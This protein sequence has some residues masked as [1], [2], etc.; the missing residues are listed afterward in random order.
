MDTKPT[1]VGRTKIM[2][3]QFFQGSQAVFAEEIYFILFLLRTRLV[4]SADKTEP[5]SY[6]V[7]PLACP[8]T[9]PPPPNPK[10][11]MPSFIGLGTLNLVSNKL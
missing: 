3:P 8:V 5:K 6:N 1:L 2:L 11:G 7:V 10:L 9:T 4:L